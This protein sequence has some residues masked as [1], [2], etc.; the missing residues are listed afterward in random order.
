MHLIEKI[1]SELQRASSLLPEEVQKLL[2]SNYLT[3]TSSFVR[4]IPFLVFH[5]SADFDGVTLKDV[6]NSFGASLV[7]T[8]V[9]TCI[10]YLVYPLK[11][12]G[13]TR[14]CLIM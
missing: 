14:L 12:T 3:S 1:H 7:A 8:T 2:L 5:R 9:F 6:I 10:Y 4:Y 11:D 13:N